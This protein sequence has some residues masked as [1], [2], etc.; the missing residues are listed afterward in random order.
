MEGLIE[1]VGGLDVHKR[2]V[3]DCSRVSGSKGTLEQ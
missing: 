2:T 3:A 1:R